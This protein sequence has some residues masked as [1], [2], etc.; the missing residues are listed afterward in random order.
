M[1]QL[2]SMPI[3]SEIRTRSP[4]G[5]FELKS[6]DVDEVQLNVK[7]LVTLTI[8]RE[9]P[10]KSFTSKEDMI[11]LKIA[12]GNVD[13]NIL[14]SFCAKMERATKKRPPKNTKIQMTYTTFSQNEHVLDLDIFGDLLPFPK[15]GKIF[16]GFP[17]FQTTG[18]SAHLAARLIPTVSK[19][20]FLC[21]CI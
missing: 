3:K 21:T 18:C 2:S 10:I 4:N 17:T 5:F 7:R 6:V 9:T 12:S 19:H 16:I 8:P 13:S 11:S 20:I 14:E 15:Q 1:H